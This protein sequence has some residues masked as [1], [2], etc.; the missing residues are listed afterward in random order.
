[1][2]KTGPENSFYQ[3]GGD[4][5][6]LSKYLLVLI[7]WWREVV[8]GTILTGAGGAGLLL[9]AELILPRYE[10]F[11]DVA[12][13]PTET[14]VSIDNT[15]RTATNASQSRR[16]DAA[17][18]REALLGLIRNGSVAQAV[19]ERLRSQGD[20]EEPK[21]ARLLE[22][23]RARLVTDSGTMG[24]IKNISDLIRITSRADGKEKAAFLANAWAEEYVKH[25]NVL[26]QQVPEDVIHGVLAELGRAQKTYA[27]AQQNLEAFLAD[28]NISEP[29]RQINLKKEFATRLRNF[30]IIS[31][32]SLLSKS[33]ETQTRRSELYKIQTSEKRK[34]IEMLHQTRRDLL[35]LQT[36]T[37]T[38]RQ[39]IEESG[40]TNIVSNNLAVLL[41]KAEAYGSLP[42]F[43]GVLDLH[44]DASVLNH[45]GGA[46]QAADLDVLSTLLQ[47]RLALTDKEIAALGKNLSE[48]DFSL[49]YS[50]L[51]AG[52]RSLSKSLTPELALLPGSAKNDSSTGAD[53]LEASLRE[54]LSESRDIPIV[55]D[56]ENDIRSLEAK[57]ERLNST[58]THLTRERDLRRSTLETLQN[59]NIELVLTMASAGAQV[60]LA[61]Q[62]VPPEDTNYPSPLLIAFLSSLAGLSAAVCFAF[63][64]NRLG[65][66]PL[67]GKH[68]RSLSEQL[69]DSR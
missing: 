60:R 26:Y 31:F 40:E 7:A 57:Q 58:L 56:V 46:D 27:A 67:L 62:A 29:E 54:F 32:E 6:P 66:Y 3:D 52:D 37:R 48:P 16:F 45:A 36:N 15:L 20:E 30:Q 21:A 64:A 53:P 12:I 34:Y 47:N 59:E 9:T 18:R 14:D 38:L 2:E 13:I 39:Q 55:K 19:A 51:N 43:S 42:D 17:A 33:L 69:R 5:V 1:M 24:T 44:I 49:L 8:L 35:R 22:Q 41:L 11:C 28:N 10:S 50:D 68:G 65:V 23:I 25:V 4:I 63:V 61:T